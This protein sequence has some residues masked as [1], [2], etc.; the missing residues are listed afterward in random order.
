MKKFNFVI[1]VHGVINTEIIA[2]DAE[3][4]V[5]ILMDKKTMFE[6]HPS[7]HIEMEIENAIITFNDD[8][9]ILN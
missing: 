4:A 2:N 9:I 3:E 7:G 5:N 8:N 6:Y 1:P